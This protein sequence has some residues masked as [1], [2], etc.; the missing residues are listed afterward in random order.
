[1]LNLKTISKIFSD[2]LTGVPTVYES[3][4]QLSRLIRLNMEMNRKLW[5]LEDSARMTELGSEHVA[6][7]KQEIDKNNQIRNNLISKMDIEITKQMGISSGP[8]EQLYSESPGMIIDRLS[9]LF[10]KLSVIRSLL[11]VIEEKD[12]LEEYTEKENMILNQ[13]E[14]IGN[15]LNSYFTKLAHKEVFFEIMQPVKIYNDDRIR[16]YI[17][18]LA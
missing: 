13:I 3:E 15:F 18:A 2:F 17:K 8:Q 5:N 7:P 12:L 10:I 9:I 16:K 1:M 14:H 11:L 6:K 4:N